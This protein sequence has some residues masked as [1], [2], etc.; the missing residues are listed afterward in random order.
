MRWECVCCVLVPL[1]VSLCVAQYPDWT[2]LGELYRFS[3]LKCVCVCVCLSAC[4]CFVCVAW[5]KNFDLNS[6]PKWVVCIV[7]N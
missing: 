4:T 5:L 7:V 1:C 6:E 3:M 2:L